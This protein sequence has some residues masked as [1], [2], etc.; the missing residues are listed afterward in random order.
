[1]GLTNTIDGDVASYLNASVSI[2]GLNHSTAAAVS[3]IND[4]FLRTN[5]LNSFYD[6][7]HH[8]TTGTATA[9]SGIINAS[10]KI[11]DEELLSKLERTVR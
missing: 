9:A 3:R 5:F 11:L 1:M 2:L 8:P 6:D 4:S 7:H 10:N